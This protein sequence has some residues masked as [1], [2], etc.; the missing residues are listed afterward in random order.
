MQESIHLC[1]LLTESKTD[2]A[3]KYKKYPKLAEL[4]F[5]LFR[6]AP[7][8][9]HNSIVDTLVCLRCFLRMKLHKELHAEKFQYWMTKLI[10][11]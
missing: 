1:N 10:T 4:Y 3:K 5:T 7:T 8:N 2:P 11:E 6:Q 9:L